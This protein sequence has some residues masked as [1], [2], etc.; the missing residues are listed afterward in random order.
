[1]IKKAYQTPS[2]RMVVLGGSPVLNTVSVDLGS[3]GHQNEAESRR[4]HRRSQ[5][6]DEEEEEW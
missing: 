1:M 2:T 4:H 6:D 5:W 3:V